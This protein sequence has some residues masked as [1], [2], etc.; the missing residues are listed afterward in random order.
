[1]SFIFMSETVHEIVH[2][3][4]LAEGPGVAR[5]KKIGEKKIGGKKLEK[6]IWKNWGFFS[7]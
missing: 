6:K 1:M 3:K 4:L 5:G 2:Y 7:L